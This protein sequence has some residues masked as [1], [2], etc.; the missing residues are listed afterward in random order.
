MVKG[1]RQCLAI[2]ERITILVAFVTSAGVI[3]LNNINLYYIL[4]QI[5]SFVAEKNKNCEIQGGGRMMMNLSN[6][7][8]VLF[9]ENLLS[10]FNI[11][12]VDESLRAIHHKFN[13]NLK[14]KS[15]LWIDRI[16]LPELTRRMNRSIEGGS[17]NQQGRQENRKV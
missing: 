17:S 10:N 11:Y 14:I 9:N 12:L 3:K 16:E 8:Q 4:S 1:L 2:S 13:L 15:L 7:W 5:T 6:V